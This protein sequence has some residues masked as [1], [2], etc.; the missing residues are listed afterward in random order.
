[1]IIMQMLQIFKE[2]AWLVHMGIL[3]GVK[4]NN[5]RRLLNYNKQL[6]IMRLFIFQAIINKTE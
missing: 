3:D 6:N 4:T 5:S 2:F 1:M